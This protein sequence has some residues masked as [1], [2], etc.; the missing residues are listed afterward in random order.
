MNKRQA[1]L[2]VSREDGANQSRLCAVPAVHECKSP[3][4]PGN[5][6]SKI[7]TLTSAP[8]SLNHAFPTVIKYKMKH[9][10]RSPYPSRIKSAEYK[11]WATKAGW[12]LNTQSISKISG[13][14]KLDIEIGFRLSRADLDNLIKPISDLLVSMGATD[15]DKHMTAVSIERTNRADVLIEIQEV[16]A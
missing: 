10:R 6:A 2:A 5:P 13:P 4:K 12:E 11:A 8:P 7:Y 3:G 9:G 16:K 14:Y 15:D 1:L